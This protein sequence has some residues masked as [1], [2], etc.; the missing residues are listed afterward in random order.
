[1]KIN[2]RND[3]HI[4][5]SEGLSAHVTGIV[6]HALSHAGERISG[7]EV[8]LKDQNGLKGG[9][10]DKHCMMEAHRDG[11]P[12][13]AVSEQAAT[14]EGAIKGAAAKLKRSVESNDA[15]E[16]TLAGRRDHK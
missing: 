9:A 15:R 6:E 3:N 16:N 4:K 10:G 7:V 1:M 12:P 2:V 5:G 11:H 14:F 13:T 8:H